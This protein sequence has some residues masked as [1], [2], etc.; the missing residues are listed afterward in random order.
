MQIIIFFY[1]LHMMCKQLAI[2]FQRLK[3]QEQKKQHHFKQDVVN[4]M[5]LIGLQLVFKFQLQPKEPPNHLALHLN[6][7]FLI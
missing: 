7:R 3:I 2:L 1:K 6:G 5:V 4:K